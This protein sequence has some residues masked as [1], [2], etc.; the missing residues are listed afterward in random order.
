MI[1][2]REG[3]CKRTK[4]RYEFARKQPTSCKHELGT[5]E[6]TQSIWKMDRTVPP[7]VTVAEDAGA[8]ADVADKVRRPGNSR[9]YKAH[10]QGLRATGCRR[11]TASSL[12]TARFGRTTAGITAARGPLGSQQRSGSIMVGSSGGNMVVRGSRSMADIAA[13]HQKGPRPPRPARPMRPARGPK[14]P[15]AELY[16]APMDHSYRAA[17]NNGNMNDGMVAVVRDRDLEESNSCR[18]SQNRCR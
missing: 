5:Q 1:G 17:Q 16:S 7:E 4:M 18:L 10:S 12:A 15:D 3:D 8:A 14:H 11:S 6:E 13:Q 9:R 2:R